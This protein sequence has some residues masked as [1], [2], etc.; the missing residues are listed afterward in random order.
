MRC[1][2]VIVREDSDDTYSLVCSVCDRAVWSKS[3]FPDAEV[4][5]ECPHCHGMSPAARARSEARRER[6]R[7]A[8][9]G[10]YN[11]TVAVNAMYI[12]D[13]GEPKSNSV[14]EAVE[15]MMQQ[16]NERWEQDD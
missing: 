5:K 12:L 6:Q 15:V 14:N 16:Y 13:G 10:F 3:S 2:Q 4:A 1:Q 8:W 11:T 9:L 7:L